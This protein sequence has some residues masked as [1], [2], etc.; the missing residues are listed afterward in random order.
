M[1]GSVELVQGSQYSHIVENQLYH[2]ITDGLYMQ[3]FPESMKENTEEEPYNQEDVVFFMKF[4]N[5]EVPLVQDIPT[6]LKKTDD[7]YYDCISLSK[8]KS[9]LDKI[10]SRGWSKDR[11]TLKPLNLYK[12]EV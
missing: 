9:Y 11:R 1:V 8:F 5:G 6:Q 7:N 2:C 12:Y 3:F 4:A 10:L